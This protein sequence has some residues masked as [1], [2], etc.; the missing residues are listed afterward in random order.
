MAVRA[1]LERVDEE[2][3]EK[4]IDKVIAGFERNL[5]KDEEQERTVAYHEVGHAIVGWFL[6]GGNPLLKLTIRPRSKGA[7]G[8]AQYLPSEVGLKHK[9]D[10]LDEMACILGGR[11]AEEVFRGE[12]TTGAHDDFRKANAIAQSLI[13]TYG[14]GSSFANTR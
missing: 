4:A 11:A 14:M 5:I 8:F 1:D 12:S 13:G 9:Q 10:L 7:L 2:C 6:P 3:F